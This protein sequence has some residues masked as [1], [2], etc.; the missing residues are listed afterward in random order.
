MANLVKFYFDVNSTTA[1]NEACFDEDGGHKSFVAV[2]MFA[3]RFNT[4]ANIIGFGVD[5]GGLERIRLLLGVD[6]KEGQLAVVGKFRI[7]L[8]ARVS[9]R[10]YNFS[11]LSDGEYVVGVAVMCFGTSL[12][13]LQQ[14]RL[15]KHRT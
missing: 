7:E 6:I 4:F 9:L 12:H 2:T 8:L 14:L 11:I 10:V 13:P 3:S 15:G 5:G 1:V